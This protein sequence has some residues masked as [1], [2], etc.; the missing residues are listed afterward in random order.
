[1]NGDRPFSWRACRRD[2]IR[3]EGV[4]RAGFALL[5]GSLQLARD[6]LPSRRRMRYGDLDFDWDHRVDTTWSNVPFRTRLRELLIG[7]QYQ[8]T[9]SLAFHE[10]MSQLAINFAE[11]TFVDLG[12][13]K[14]RALL[15]ASE[16]PFCRILGVELL[17][18]LC[19]I[20]RRNVAKCSGEPQRRRT[21]EI[22]CCDAREF[23]LPNE[24][25]VVFLFDPFP[26]VI[27]R[28][29]L[30]KIEQSLQQT[31]RPLW[32]AYQ[33][34]VSEQVLG[35]CAVL[36]KSAGNLQYAIYRN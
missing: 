25:L 9:D 22:I 20:A 28:Q 30:A 14:G 26:P 8:P 11:F 6:Y 4:L 32:V 33:N 7:R 2:R 3:N 12:C 29:V 24:P 5:Q 10:I 18:E 13:G 31:P 35:E 17:P 16:Y 23:A 15:L 19:A 34:P 27:L 36:R 21:I 1:M